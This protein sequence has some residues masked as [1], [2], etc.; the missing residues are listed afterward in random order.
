MRP[1][2]TSPRAQAEEAGPGEELRLVAYRVSEAWDAPLAPAPLAREWMTRT[3]DGFANRC[4]PLLIANQSGWVVLSSH[5]VRAVW[6]GGDALEN[7]EVELL[8]GAPPCPAKSHFGHGILTWSLPYLIRTPPGYNLL[9]RGPANLPKDGASALEGTVETDWCN[10]TFTVNWKLTRPGLRVTFEEGE[11]I[12]MLVPQ[13]RGELERFHPEVRGLHD[14]PGVAP[15]YSSWRESR[16]TFL[17][18]L[19]VEDSPAHRMA[20][21]KHYLHGEGP[22]GSVAPEHQRKLALRPFREVGGGK[23]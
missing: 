4:L 7:V 1:D 9:V 10:A 18:E 13:R 11:P 12:A 5:R 23:R 17:E 16:S 2:R 8:G 21:Q 14:D 19:P 15:A 3:R 6:D 22:D 20:W